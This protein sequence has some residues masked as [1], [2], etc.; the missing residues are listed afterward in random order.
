MSWY[1]HITRAESWRQSEQKPI[2]REEWLACVEADEELRRVTPQEVEANK[3]F[4]KAD[5]GAWVERRPDGSERILAWFGY[6]GGMIDVRNPDGEA[7]GKMADVAE[8]LH[9]NVIDE[10]DKVLIDPGPPH[11]TWREPAAPS[12]P[13][14]ASLLGIIGVAIVVLGLAFV[15]WLLLWR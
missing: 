15:L 12:T 8:A 3:P 5:D 11:P 6:H 13:L 9:A 1:V 10:N 4:V 2:A 14:P 7:L